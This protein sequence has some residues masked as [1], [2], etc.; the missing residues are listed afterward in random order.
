MAEGSREGEGVGNA[1]APKKKHEDVET[2]NLEKVTDFVEE[3]KENSE[4]LGK[5]GGTLIF[6][7]CFGL[8]HGF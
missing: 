1:P 8:M 5:V 3:S 4:E 7:T 6:Y 2:Q